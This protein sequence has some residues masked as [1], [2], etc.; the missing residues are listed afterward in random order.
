[1]PTVLIIRHYYNSY[2]NFNLQLNVKWR[3]LKE[4][5]SYYTCHHS[6]TILHNTAAKYK[7][8]DSGWRYGATENAG[9]ENDGPSK[10]RGW[11]MQDWNL[12]DQI[13]GPENGAM[14]ST[15]V[16]CW[17]GQECEQVRMT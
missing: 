17:C 9:L 15:V 10:S 3:V 1:M 13:A 4:G 16:F 2:A 7:H 8:D 5:S 12:A 6:H 14:L 11:K